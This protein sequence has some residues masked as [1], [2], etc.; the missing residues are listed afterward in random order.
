[1]HAI[2]EGMRLAAVR[3]YQVLVPPRNR[4]RSHHAHAARLLDVPITL[5]TA[6]DGSAFRIK[7]SVG[8]DLQSTDRLPGFCASVHLQN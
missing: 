1:M 2:D 6:I 8:T 4:L 7:S 5:M 3:R